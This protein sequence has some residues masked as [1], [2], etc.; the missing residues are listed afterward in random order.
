MR[1]Q[2]MDSER[3]REEEINQ[4]QGHVNKKSWSRRERDCYDDRDRERERWRLDR[5]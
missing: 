3:D 4:Q 1:R 2:K 5:K